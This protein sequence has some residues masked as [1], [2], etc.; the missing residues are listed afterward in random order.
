M[1]ALSLQHAALP[2][3]ADSATYCLTVGDSPTS[4]LIE[5]AASAAFDL[6]RA[7]ETGMGNGRIHRNFKML[8]IDKF[9]SIWYI[10]P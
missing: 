8:Y 7:F 4:G 1:P 5:E 2:L 10:V 3:R 6:G 9:D